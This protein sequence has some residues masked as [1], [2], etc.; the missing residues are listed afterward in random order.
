MKNLQNLEEYYIQTQ[1]CMKITQKYSIFVLK[2]I[3]NTEDQRIK[4]LAT[5]LL[6]NWR[7]G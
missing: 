7:E 1:N 2:Q 6:E 4:L 3:I 5:G